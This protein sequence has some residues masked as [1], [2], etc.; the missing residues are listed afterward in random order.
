MKKLVKLVA[1]VAATVAVAQG[2]MAGDMGV[3][4]DAP[5]GYNVTGLV[6]VYANSVGNTGTVLSTLDSASLSGLE[7]LWLTQPNVPYTSSQL[8]T[9]GAYL[10][11]GGRIAFLGE[12][13]AIAPT[14][15]DNITAAI[16]TLGGHISINNLVVDGGFRTA[17]RTGG[18]TGGMILDDPLTEGVNQYEYAAFAPLVIGAGVRTL[19]LGND[20][21]SIM[22][23]FENIGAGSIFLITDQ[24]P[25]DAGVVDNAQWDNTRMFLN[26]LQADTGAPPPPDTVPEPESLALLG[27][28]A[29]GLALA[30][31]RSRKVPA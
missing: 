3:F 27:L 10:A 9:L 23:A 30:R 17:T 29:L 20:G 8:A 12:H 7:L 2:A 6:D 1:A 25:L 24:N 28:G 13:G 14:Q 11:G 26:L 18:G 31:R 22:M 15:N 5:F 4:G 19:M 21:T 16:A